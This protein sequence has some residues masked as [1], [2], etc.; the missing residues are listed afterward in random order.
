[1]N[2]GKEKNYMEVSKADS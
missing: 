1:M 2:A